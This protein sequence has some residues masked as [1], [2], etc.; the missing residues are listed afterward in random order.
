MADFS[1]KWLVNADWLAA[2]LNTPD[3]VILDG[4]WHLPS[5]TIQS[6]ALL[7]VIDH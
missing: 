3:V 2:H 6:L 4:N 1:D 7:L 5:C